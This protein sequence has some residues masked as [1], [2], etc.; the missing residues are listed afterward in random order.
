M[1]LPGN[2]CQQIV[3]DHQDAVD[4]TAN[5]HIFGHS[6]PIL[7]WHGYQQQKKERG[8]FQKPEDPKCA[9]QIHEVAK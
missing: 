2:G 5:H 7:Q 1:F 6:G 4:P 9:Q 8:S 3:D